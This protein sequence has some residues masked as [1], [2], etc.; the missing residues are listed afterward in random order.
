MLIDLA[1]IA[2][3]LR[4][5]IA[6]GNNGRAAFELAVFLGELMRGRHEHV[7]MVGFQDCLGARLV[8]GLDVTVEKEDRASFD[9]EFLQRFAERRN[10]HIVERPFDL[11][12]GEDALV[13]LEAQR[14][15]D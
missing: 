15:L 4:A 10:F 6:I 5:D 11:A 12:I 3:N 13:D 7:G 14:P 1:E 2:A 8:V 9:A